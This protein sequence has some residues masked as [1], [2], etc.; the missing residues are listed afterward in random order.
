MRCGIK[1]LLFLNWTQPVMGCR[2]MALAAGGAG[3][4][5]F[6]EISGRVLPVA[7]IFYHF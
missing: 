2:C 4:M 1:W 5:V 7:V 6:L 3:T